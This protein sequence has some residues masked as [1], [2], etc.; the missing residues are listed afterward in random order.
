MGAVVERTERLFGES[1]WL[2]ELVGGVNIVSYEWRGSDSM[3]IKRF[4]MK[5]S[6]LIDGNFFFLKSG[7]ER[8]LER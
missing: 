2:N 6:W 4:L 8:D 7:F 3:L 5:S 1:I